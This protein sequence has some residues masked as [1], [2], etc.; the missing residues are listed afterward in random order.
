MIDAAI[1]KTRRDFAEIPVNVEFTDFDPYQ[2]Y[3]QMR[4][5]V[6]S[7]GTLYIWKGAS[8][9]PMWDEETNWMVRAVH[10]W[11]HISQAFDFTMGGEYEGFRVAA[12]KAPQ[13]APLYLSEIAMQAA[14]V[15]TYGDFA[16]A[17]KIV[18][19]PEEEFRQFRGV[20]APDTP[21]E[22]VQTVSAMRSVMSDEEV[23]AVLGAAGVDGPLLLIEASRIYDALVE[24]QLEAGSGGLGDTTKYRGVEAEA[25]NRCG[26]VYDKFRGTV[27]DFKEAYHQIAWTQPHV[28]RSAVLRHWAAC[29]REEWAH[30]LDT[31]DPDFVLE[32]E[33]TD[34]TEF[35]DGYD[36]NADG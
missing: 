17:Q 16:A 13:L 36:W 31:C 32:A 27:R 14:V 23:A 8:D 24:G 35:L 5:Q 21:A 10:D 18:L 26:A 3:E 6:L 4:D 12:R 22:M 11:D 33:E 34:P 19:L 30:H 28:S 2:S 29:K 25:C 20:D 15:N 1:A 7:T 9:V